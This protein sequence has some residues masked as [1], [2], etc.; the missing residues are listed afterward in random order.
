VATKVLSICA[1]RLAERDSGPPP[2]RS[3]REKIDSRRSWKGKP[4]NGGD[5][6]EEEGQQPEK[7]GEE[8]EEMGEEMEEKPDLGIVL[9][10]LSRVE[11]R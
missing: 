9:A 7:H 4:A 6:H 1:Q 10:A 5:G 11:R 3:S 8:W 2:R